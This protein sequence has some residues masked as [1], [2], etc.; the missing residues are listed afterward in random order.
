[1]AESARQALSV[2]RDSHLF[3]W[4]LIPFLALI[5]Y[6]YVVEVERKKWNIIMAGLAF[7]ALEWLFEIINAIWFHVSGFSAIWVTPGNSAYILLIGLT[8]EISM[9][10]AIAGVLFAKVLPEDKKMKILGINNRWALAVAFSVFCVFV[11]II[12]NQWHVLI[13]NYSWWN[14]PNFWLIILIG[15]L[16]YFVLAF[17]LHDMPSMKKKI[18]IVSG[19]YFVDLVLILVFLVGL[20]WI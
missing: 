11:E 4:Y 19:I 7:Y 12:L 16:P 2:L 20:K 17:W 1:M 5:I 13:W 14:W 3:S 15:Y 18:S 9:M 6:V 10:F 8:I